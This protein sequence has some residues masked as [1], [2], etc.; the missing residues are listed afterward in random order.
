FHPALKHVATG[1][2]RLGIRTLFN[3]LGPLVNPAGSAYQLIGVGHADLLDLLAGALARLGIRHAL[4]VCGRD[5]LDEVSLSGPTLVREVIGHEVRER[6]WTP[7]NFDL[8]RCSLQELHADGPEQSA[9]IIRGILDGRE[10]A[11]RDIV[12]ANAAAALIA[13]EHV[14]VP[15]D[16]VALARETLD[17]GKA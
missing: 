12:L 14:D 15:R 7:E 5:G 6:E 2:R 8:P 3:C 4:L 1:G 9:A 16:G 10:G 11:V 17:S 13:A